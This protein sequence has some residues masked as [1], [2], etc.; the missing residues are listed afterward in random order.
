MKSTKM[1][2][3]RWIKHTTSCFD[4]HTVKSAQLT[5]NYAGSKWRK[6]F[7]KCRTQANNAKSLRD[8]SMQI[9]C[10]LITIHAIKMRRMSCSTT[11][12]AYE[13]GKKLTSKLNSIKTNCLIDM[14]S[15][16]NSK[17]KL[18]L[19]GNALLNG[20]YFAHGFKSV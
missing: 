1:H 6:C 9:S 10:W 14:N 3:M 19:G 17:F 20:N 11:T 16:A 12:F 8:F 18:S 7:W 13:K 2:F 4:I 15:L 5:G